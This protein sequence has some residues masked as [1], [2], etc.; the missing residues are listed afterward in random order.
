[1]SNGR[2]SRRNHRLRRERGASGKWNAAS[3]TAPI[4]VLIL[5]SSFGGAVHAPGFQRNPAFRLA[6][7]ASGKAENAKRVA[8]ALGIPYAT[9]DWERMLDEAPADLVSIATPVDQHYPMARAALERG[10]HVLCEKP[11]AMNALEAKELLELARARGVVHVVNHE[12]R[13]YPARAAL[14]RR[15]GEGALGKVEHIVIRDLIPGWAR[16]ASRRLTWLTERGRGGGYLGA[17]GSHHVDQLL[18]WGGPIERVFCTLRTLAAE[19]PDASPGQRGITADDSFTLLARFS[20]GARGVVDLFGGSHTRRVGMEV[21]GSRDAL[22]VVDPYR[23][24]RWK[25]DGSFEEVEI[26]EDLRLTPTP[27]E[28]LLAPFSAKVEMIREAIQEGKR[29][30]PDFEDGV[31][32]QEVLDAARRSDASGSWER[33]GE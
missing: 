13:H 3:V 2:P 16:N 7:I 17:L 32:I 6:G 4:R 18:L 12:F 8:A 19:G 11:F 25:Q 20:E 23:L 33:V 10:L 26:P 15:I 31:R 27:E 1:M 5:G 30:G 24:G 21:F 29:P 14:T 9:D 22:A 28:S